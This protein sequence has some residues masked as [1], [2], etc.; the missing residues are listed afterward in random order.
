[1]RESG[2]PLTALSLVL[3]YHKGGWFIDLNGNY[4]DRI[5][6]GYSPSYRYSSTLAAREKIEHNV[7]DANGNVME[8]AVEQ[9]K[10]HGGFMLDASIGKSIN[11]KR[12][13]SMSIN[14]S[15]TNLLNNQNIVTGGYD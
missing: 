9:A 4:Y 1:M 2:T 3:S 5:Y 11:L 12:G 14:L 6:L 8:S 13:R 15:V 10:G 7:Y